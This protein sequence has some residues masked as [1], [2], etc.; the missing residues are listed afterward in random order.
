MLFLSLLRSLG[1]TF[2]NSS[3]LHSRLLNNMASVDWVGQDLQCTLKGS[4]DVIQGQVFT[5]DKA[6]D[7]LVLKDHSIK[8]MAN[9][10]FLKGSLIEPSS[11][12]LSGNT[13]APDLK[14]IPVVSDST[15]ERS[16]S[17]LLP[18]PFDLAWFGS[19]LV[20]LPRRTGGSSPEFLRAL[21][22]LR[23]LPLQLNCIRTYHADSG[24]ST[25]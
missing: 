11:V 21:L 23:V 22:L 25:H 20:L 1:R 5:Y 14:D 10:R 8:D 15:I 3:A 6:S 13:A 17:Y 12:K 24:V 19:S 4:G 18:F 9:Y 16:G 7:S 2:L